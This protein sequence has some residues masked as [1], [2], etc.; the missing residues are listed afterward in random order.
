MV[1]RSIVFLLL[2]FIVSVH[3][4]RF[5]SD[6]T[7]KIAQFA[8]LHY[9]EG[10]SVAWGPQQDINSTRVMNRVLA[11]EKPDLV[12]F[13]GDQITGNNIQ[14]NSTAYWRKAIQ[15]CL[16][17]NTP[18][19]SI[20]GNHDDLAVAK[21]SRL[22]LMRFDTSFGLSLSQFGPTNIHG[23]SNYFLQIESDI[24][25]FNL[26]FL[27]SGGG[28]Y[29]EIVYPDQVQWYVNTST[30]LQKNGETPAL[31]FFHIP[32]EEYENLYNEK[33]CV[34]VNYDG[35]DAQLRNYGLF[36]AFVKM[37]DVKAAFVGH[38]HGNDW[39][40]KTKEAIDLCYGRHT[41]YGGYG[42]WDR[43]SRMILLNENDNSIKTW[44]RMENGSIIHTDSLFF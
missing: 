10:E 35:N 29:D 18:W 8:D 20:F 41:G 17:T 24:K 6:G 4:L 2:F 7:F 25:P 15:P 34:G 37:G 5:R 28:S 22:E 32:T 3:N 30:I 9:G 23:V 1:M 11:A 13:T 33:Y 27:D 19:A 36:S 31:A 43:G 39:C 16:D 12:V 40:C 14:S 21:G 44:I 38:D 42:T 26:F